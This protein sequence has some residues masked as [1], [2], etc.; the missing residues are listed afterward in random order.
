MWI[1]LI[2]GHELSAEVATEFVVCELR[3]F[4][5]QIELI[6]DLHGFLSGNRKRVRICVLASFAQII[7]GQVVYDGWFCRLTI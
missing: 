1:K 3:S 4:G 7:V 5:I 6:I 2:S